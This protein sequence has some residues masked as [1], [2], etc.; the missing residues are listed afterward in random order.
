MSARRT[1]I[2]L[3]AAALACGALA[4]CGKIGNLDR[5]GPLFHRGG[6]LTGGPTSATSAQA[7][8]AARKGGDPTHPINTVDPR[9]VNSE[10]APPRTLPIPGAPQDPGKSQP[11]G[12][13][14]DPYAN[15]R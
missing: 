1:L 6:T 4:G 5:P 11:P 7:T 14:P 10:P 2:A 9:D 3:S 12:A 13:L 8:D 15:P